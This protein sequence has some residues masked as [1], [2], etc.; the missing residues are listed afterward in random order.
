VGLAHPGVV[1]QWHLEQKGILTVSSLVD[2]GSKDPSTGLHLTVPDG[3]RP[4]GRGRGPD[5]R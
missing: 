5:S 4:R 1:Q 3:R 2:G